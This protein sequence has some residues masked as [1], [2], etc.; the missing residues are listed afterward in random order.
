MRTSHGM[1]AVKPGDTGWTPAAVKASPP[2]VNVTFVLEG[3]MIACIYI[4]YGCD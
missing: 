2:H 4:T 1:T 3:P